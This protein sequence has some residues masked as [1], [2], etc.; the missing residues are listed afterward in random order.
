MHACIA[1]KGQGMLG[2][3]FFKLGVQGAAGPP[4]G[5]GQR[6]GQGSR[7]PEAPGKS[8]VLAFFEGI[9]GPLLALIFVFN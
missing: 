7:G 2:V 6:P 4:V 8:W 3:R 1:V 9:S 5:P